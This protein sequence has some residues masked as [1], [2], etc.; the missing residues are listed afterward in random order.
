[1]S[2]FS[3]SLPLVL[4][5]G[6]PGYRLNKTMLDVVKQNFKNLVLTAPGERV[7]IPDFGVGIRNYLFE[8]N[9]SSTFS[10]IRGRLASQTKKYMPFVSIRNVQFI[11]PEEQQ[12]DIG[13]G[14]QIVITY[15]VV[16]LGLADTLKVE[17]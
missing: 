5:P 6:S 15:E 3:P 8:Q 9:D 12:N 1:M 4:D 10:E 2:G 17:L 14:V 7:M 13:N 16:P 11:N